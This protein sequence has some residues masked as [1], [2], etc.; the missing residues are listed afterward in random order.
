[1]K[2]AIQIN[3]YKGDGTPLETE[4]IFGYLEL[5]EN[6]KT[7]T[8]TFERPNTQQSTTTVKF[9]LSEFSVDEIGIRVKGTNID[10][11]GKVDIYAASENSCV[12]DLA[13]VSNQKN[14]LLK[15]YNE[16]PKFYYDKYGCLEDI[17][18]VSKDQYDLER[19][20]HYKE[21]IRELE[22]K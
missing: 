9:N 21:K 11:Y 14:R 18:K 1:M 22:K 7:S 4:Y 8:I 2:V 3:S 5:K 12:W 20:N 16:L 15:I 13:G 10:G 6:P 17:D 19:I